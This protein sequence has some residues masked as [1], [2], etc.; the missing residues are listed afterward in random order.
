MRE[1]LHIDA[2]FS[3]TT[4]Q[5]SETIYAYLLQLRNNKGDAF[6]VY[7]LCLNSYPVFLFSYL[8]VAKG[9]LDGITVHL[10][11]LRTRADQPIQKSCFAKP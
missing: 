1:R 7:K 6:C 2:M 11:V 4:E 5:R 8:E 3:K 10:L 9:L